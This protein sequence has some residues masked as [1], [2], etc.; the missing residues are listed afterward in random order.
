MERFKGDEGYLLNPRWNQKFSPKLSKK[1]SQ[2]DAFLQARTN[3]QV[4]C[5]LGEDLEQVWS[6]KIEAFFLPFPLLF[7]P[8]KERRERVFGC[9]NLVLEALEGKWNKS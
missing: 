9:V 7:Q 2:D 6:K 1:S 5:E 8:T 3:L 4:V